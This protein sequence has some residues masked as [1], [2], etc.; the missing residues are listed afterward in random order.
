MTVE[1][2]LVRINPTDVVNVPYAARSISLTVATGNVTVSIAG[3][4]GVI[5][6]TGISH[7]WA[8]DSADE[9]LSDAFTFTGDATAVAYLTITRE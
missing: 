9:K 1:A 8:V 4:L 7:T 5:V 6:G 3:G 2:Q